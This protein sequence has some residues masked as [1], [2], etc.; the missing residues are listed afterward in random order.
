MMKATLFALPLLVLGG[1]LLAAGC[2][3]SADPDPDGVLVT[4]ADDGDACGS[5]AD[6]CSYLC[7]S[8]G[9]CGP[10]LTSCTLDNGSC[11]ADTDCCSNLCADDGYC[12]LP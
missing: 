2:T 3:V 12:G 10:P 8:D 1:V 5:D 7:A 4:C 9:Y 11:G 6:C